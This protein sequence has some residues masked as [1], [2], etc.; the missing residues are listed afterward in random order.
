MARSSFRLYEAK[1]LPR[2]F[3]YPDALVSFAAGGEHPEIFPWVFIDAPSA[4]GK[5]AYEVRKQDDRDLVPFASVED[6]RKD[7]ACFDARDST[8]SGPVL[9]LVVDG[10]GRSYSYGSF[11]EWL[12][13][14][15]EDAARWGK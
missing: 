11:G 3:R 13:T 1:Q 14:A 5:L 10:S 15:Q 4:V 7:I 6:D 8:G 2:A 12:A 9:M